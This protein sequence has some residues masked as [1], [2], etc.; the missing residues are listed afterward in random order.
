LTPGEGR[1]E[2]GILRKKTLLAWSTNK[3]LDTREAG[4][5]LLVQAGYIF[6][7]LLSRNPGLAGREGYLTLAEAGLSLASSSRIA[8]YLIILITVEDGTVFAFAGRGRDHLT[9]RRDPE[10]TL[11][12]PVKRAGYLTLAKAG[13]LLVSSSRVVSS[14]LLLRRNLAL[15]GRAGILDTCEAGLCLLVQAGAFF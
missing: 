13:L 12:S 7:P 1:R 11:Y 10:K 8:I 14:T 4:L 5:R 6:R 2:R 3:V 9:P 15:A